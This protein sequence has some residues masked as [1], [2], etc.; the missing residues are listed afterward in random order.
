MTIRVRSSLYFT[1]SECYSIGLTAIQQGKDK[2][3]HDWLKEAWQR[4]PTKD[5]QDHIDIIQALT[6]ASLKVS[7]GINTHLYLFRHFYKGE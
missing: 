5:R 2:L 6:N 3:G 1:A 4:V 7:L